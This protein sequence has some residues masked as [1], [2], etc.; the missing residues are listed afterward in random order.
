MPEY[1][2]DVATAVP[3]AE[4]VEANRGSNAF[5]LR[6]KLLERLPRLVLL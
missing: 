1:A 4:G 2:M 5:L 6:R 3:W